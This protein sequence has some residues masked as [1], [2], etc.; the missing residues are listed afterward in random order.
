[1]PWERVSA[2]ND[3]LNFMKDL[4]QLR[5][6]VA[7]M[8]QYGKVSLEEVEPD[9]VAVEWQYEG[10]ILKAYF[11]HSKKDVVLEREQVDLISLGSISDDRLIIQPNGFVIYREN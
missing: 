6:E 9:V 8:I 10:Q 7:G 1:M 4:I 2:D 3:M 11:N 5:K